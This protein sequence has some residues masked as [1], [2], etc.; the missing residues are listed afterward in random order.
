MKLSPIV[1]KDGTVVDKMKHP[2]T[3]LNKFSLPGKLVPVEYKDGKVEVLPEETSITHSED[4]QEMWDIIWLP[5][6]QN[7][8]HYFDS[9]DEIRNKLNAEW[10][11]RPKQCDVISPALR[12]KIQTLLK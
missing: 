11:I 6:G 5:Y 8:Y 2:K 9:F 7:K 12:K 3:D 1:L 10:A 4:K